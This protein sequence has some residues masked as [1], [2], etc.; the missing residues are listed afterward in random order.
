VL[1]P[2]GQLLIKQQVVPLNT[3]RD[4]DTYGGAPVAGDRRFSLTAALNGSPLTGQAVQEDFAPAQYFVM[5]DDEKL[6]APSFEA[7]DGGYV[8]T[9]TATRFDPQEIIASPVGYHTITVG[10]QP[11]P[12]A[13]AAVQTAAASAPAPYTM[14]PEQLQAFS[15]SGAASRAPLRRVGRA[16]FR[17]DAVIPNAKVKPAQWAIVPRGAGAPATLD[18]SVRTWSDYQAALNTLNRG[19]AQWQLLPRHELAS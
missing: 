15:R 14:T 10:A 2:F 4:I 13:G 17:N 5:S 19:G 16:R 12:P 1:D 8:F 18:P 7:M 3:G 11:S 6:S 9:S